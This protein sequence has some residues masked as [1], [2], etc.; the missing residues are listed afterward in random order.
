MAEGAIDLEILTPE[1]VALHEKVQSITAP[2]VDG[3]FGVL[4]GHRPLLAALK[5][6]IVSYT[7]DGQEVRV[8]VGPG[9]VEILDDHAVLLTDNLVRKEDVDPVRARLDLK[10]ADEALDKLEAE[11]GSA[12]YLENMRK[13]LWAAA[14]LT[15]YGDPPP[16]TVHTYSE[17]LSGPQETSE[18]D[19]AVEAGE[20]E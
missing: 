4:P 3:E 20:H 18:E 14:R 12:A 1:G 13:E 8:A 16:P 5:T 9:F 2:S 19:H 11:P 7:K 15:L 17:V 10:D 6:G